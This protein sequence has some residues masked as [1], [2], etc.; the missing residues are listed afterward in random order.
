[1][2]VGGDPEHCLLRLVGRDMRASP[3]S[4]RR[5]AGLTGGRILNY[6]QSQRAGASRTPPTECAST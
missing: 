5:L 4:L 1:M 2:Q 6:D 3:A